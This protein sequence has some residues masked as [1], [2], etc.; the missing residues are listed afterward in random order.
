MKNVIRI[1][2]MLMVAMSV[3]DNTALASDSHHRGA[4]AVTMW[5]VIFN[6]PDKCVG[7]PGGDAKCSSVDV[8]GEAFLETIANGAPDPSLIAPNLDSKLAVLYATGGKTS[9]SGRI[10][11]AAS[12]YRGTPD[13]RMTLPAGADPM[14][15]GRGLESENAEIHLVIRD[16]GR[17]NRRDLLPQ[18]TNFLDP[19]CSDP[20]LLYFAGKN[21]CADVQFAIFAAHESGTD[22]VYAFAKSTRPLRRAYATLLRDGDIVRAVVNTRLGATH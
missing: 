16:H 4:R 21:I 9:A 19:Y 3:I 11:L 14:G 2:V 13:S 1:L 7:N 12:I 17:A 15:F 8:F 10:R 18:I 22:D 6:D 20:N 5:W